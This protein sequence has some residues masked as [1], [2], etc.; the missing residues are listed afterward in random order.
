[1][2]VRENFGKHEFAVYSTADFYKFIY[3]YIVY[4]YCDVMHLLDINIKKIIDK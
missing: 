3:I 2:S 1:M 4:G